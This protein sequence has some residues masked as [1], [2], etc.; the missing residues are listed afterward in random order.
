MEIPE[1]EELHYI[2]NEELLSS[3]KANKT[4]L[5]S[6]AKRGSATAAYSLASFYQD[7]ANTSHIGAF[8]KGLKEFEET[9]NEA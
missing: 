3:Y 1:Y 2:D 5:I 6:G 7:I 9:G 8:Y 4:L